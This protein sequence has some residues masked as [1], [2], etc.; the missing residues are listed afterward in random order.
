MNNY[1]KVYVFLLAT[2]FLGC[3]GL[4]L[5]S[6]FSG[7]SPQLITSD[8][9]AYYTW[10]RSI[11]IDRDI[12]FSNDYAL[13]YPPDPLPLEAEQITPAG[14]VVNKYPVGLAILQTPGMLTGHLIAWAFPGVVANGISWPYQ[15]CVPF[16]LLLF[17]ISGL[18]LLY[19][20]MLLLGCKPRESIFFSFAGIVCTNLIHYLAKEPAMPHAAGV[21]VICLLIHEI[22]RCKKE[23]NVG[24]YKTVLWGGL[25][26]L[27]FLIRNSNVFIFPFFGAL[28]WHKHLLGFKTVILLGIGAGVV[29]LIQPVSLFVLW[30]EFHLTTYPNEGFIFSFTRLLHVLLHPRHGLFLYHP[31]YLLLIACSLF[32]LT[33]KNVRL[34]SSAALFSFLCLLSLNGSWQCWWFGDSFGN[35]S[36]IETI[37]VLSLC[38]A[39]AY[40]QF[41]ASAKRDL[42]TIALACSLCVMNL[43]IWGGYL[44]KQYPHDGTHSVSEVYFWPMS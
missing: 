27:L 4:L 44:L 40:S 7:D 16:S 29:G 2:L 35:R 6:M 19:R 22:S 33:G 12:D 5:L 1:T 8:G 39:L 34:L 41:H 30:G 31:W 32:G 38:A 25:L 26:G 42:V 3:M 13:A 11:V 18:W 28:L 9:K 20:S 15:I 17:A 21:A 36:F 23:Q 14:H 10:V 37:P 24:V 43:Y